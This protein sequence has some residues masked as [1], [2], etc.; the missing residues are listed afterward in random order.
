[1]IKDHKIEQILSSL[2]DSPG[3][4][5]M[6]D[7]GGKIIYIGKANSLKKRVSS[8]F[9]KSGHDAK[10]GVLVKNICDIEYIATDSEIEAL[11]L[12]NNLIKKHKPKFNVRLKDDKRYPYIAVTLNEEYPRI[13]YTRNINKKRDR[14]FG[15]FTDARAA[16]NTAALINRTLKLK[17]CRRDLPLKKNERPCLN[18][19]IN[20]CSGACTG[21]ITKEE[22]RALI[23]DAL[24]LLEGNIDP[25]MESLNRRMKK[26]SLEMDYEKAARLRDIIFDIQKISE[27]QKVEVPSGINQDYIAAG[28]FGDE[29][30]LVIFEFR[31]GILTGRKINIFDNAKYSEAED[32][33][34][35][36]MIDYYNEGEIPS[37][38]VC[39]T[40]INDLNIIS[41]HLSEKASKKVSISAAVSQNDKSVIRLIKKNIDMIA[42]ER[43]ISR[44][45]TP[46]AGTAALQ[47]ALKLDSEPLIIECFDISNFHG[48]DSV[49]SMVMFRN[50]KPDKKNYRRY[51]IRG[52]DSPDDP[53]M[54]H[55][56]VSRRI[57][58]LVNEDRELPDLMV[59]DGGPTQLSRAIEAAANFNTGINIISVAKKLEEIYTSP[60]EKPLRFQDGSPQLR[61]IQNIRD[62]AH[63]FAITY[64]RKLRDKKTT[65]SE[66]DAIP[67]I[68]TKHRLSL[69]KYFKSVE[70][71]K[72]APVSELV[73]AEGIGEKTALKVYSFFHE[74]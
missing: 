15:P 47:E 56:A 11:L 45:N 23:D 5:M 61:L 4:Y 32:I 13:I 63:R 52:Y 65:S 48:Q 70:K 44:E 12:E 7:A 26:A 57:Q 73:K 35:T 55:E 53:G 28:I 50:G 18:F 20:R 43:S 58:F 42:A 59:I 37:R 36:F 2:P 71:I 72:E 9:R 6:L 16:K 31:N 27:T 29:A 24:N 1:M 60:S 10:T 68:G 66:L 51:K 30:L 38:I 40:R 8:Y 25:V 17:T 54:I 62:E 41:S 39:E 74:K 21:K 34:R 69:L 14:F 46:D 22:Y 49:A 64:H 67:D 33:I 3:I 19:Q